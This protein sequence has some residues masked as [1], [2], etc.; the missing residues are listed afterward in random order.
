LA[1]CVSRPESGQND[2]KNQDHE[3]AATEVIRQFFP[4]HHSHFKPRENT[5]NRSLPESD[6]QIAA[7]TGEGLCL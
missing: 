4:K 5:S 3:A 1:G 7:V 6:L 2:D